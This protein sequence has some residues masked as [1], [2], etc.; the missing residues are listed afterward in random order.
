MAM[1]IFFALNGL[2]IVFMLY[3]LANFWKEGHGPRNNARKYA[4]ELGERDWSDVVV[5]TYPVSHCAQGG[6]SVIPFR[7]LDRPSDKPTTG[8]ISNAAPEMPVRRFSTR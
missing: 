4:A 6:L 7:T 1:T 8:T 3:V 2:G 5:V